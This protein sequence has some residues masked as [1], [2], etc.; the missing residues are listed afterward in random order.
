M[1]DRVV[2]IKIPELPISCPRCLQLAVKF[3]G[4]NTRFSFP[5]LIWI[6]HVYI[7]HI[8]VRKIVISAS[9]SNNQCTPP[10]LS[11]DH[12]PIGVRLKRVKNR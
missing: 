4:A 1:T 8:F 2:T 6:P 9:S 12:Y 7:A 3:Q 10:L 11:N 5:I